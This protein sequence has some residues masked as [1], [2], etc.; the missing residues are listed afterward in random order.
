MDEA[1][2]DTV[3]DS[4]RRYLA[5]RPLAADTA[6]GVCHWWLDLPGPTPPVA[7]VQTALERLAA[8]GHVVAVTSGKRQVWRRA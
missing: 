8:A 6:E 2:I 4:I 5:Q 7:V 3:A 1:L